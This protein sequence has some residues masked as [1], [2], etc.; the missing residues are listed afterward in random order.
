MTTTTATITRTTAIRPPT[1]L[2]TIAAMLTPAIP[3]ILPSCGA[4]ENVH[5]HILSFEQ[6][7]L[8]TV[9]YLSVY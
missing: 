4:A 2:P 3:G 1:L 5:N 7:M 8:Y 6:L 9:I